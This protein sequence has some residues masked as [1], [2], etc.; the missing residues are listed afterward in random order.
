M[1]RNPR[2]RTVMLIGAIA[3]LII[4]FAFVGLFKDRITYS[5]IFRNFSDKIDFVVNA[6]KLKIPEDALSFSIYDMDNKNYIFYE[7]GGQLPT[8]ASLAKLFA[9]DYALTVVKLDDVFEANEET[10]KLVPAGSSLAYLKPGTYTARQIMQAMLVPSGN[11]AAYVLAYNIGKKYLGAGHSAKDYVK[12]FVKNLSSHLVHEG[13]R[14]TELFDPSGFSMQASTNLDDINKVTLKL[15]GYDFVKECIG[16]SSFTIHTKQGNFTWKNTNEFLDTT[17]L[18]YNEHIKG[19]KTGTMGSSY[20]L[21]ALYED[22]GKNYLITCLASHSNKD[23]Y[24]A[25]QAA[26]NTIINKR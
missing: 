9:I 20:N 18:F 6:N 5:N 22:N 4:V 26:I 10:L 14:K 7:G 24:K 8:I 21:I 25:V 12:H 1:K 19:V 2:K 23:R 15:L 13:Y 16:K 11:D 17:S 3:C